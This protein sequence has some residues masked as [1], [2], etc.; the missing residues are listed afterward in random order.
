MEFLSCYALST[1]FRAVGGAQIPVLGGGKMDEIIL[2]CC[3]ALPSETEVG[4]QGH[5]IARGGAGNPN[6]LI[7]MTLPPRKMKRLSGTLKIPAKM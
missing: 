5:Q 7:T 6:L 2:T 1:V 3:P 4:V